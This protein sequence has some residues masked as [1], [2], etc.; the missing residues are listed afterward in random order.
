M[1][2]EAKER[3]VLDKK[4][5]EEPVLVEGS[6]PTPSQQEVSLDLISAVSSAQR[7]LPPVGAPSPMT[8]LP[9]GISPE[10]TTKDRLMEEEIAVHEEAPVIRIPYYILRQR[11]PRILLLE[12]PKQIST[13]AERVSYDQSI[14]A[15]LLIIF[16]A[17]DLSAILPFEV[18]HPCPLRDI[19]FASRT[20]TADTSDVAVGALPD[21][22]SRP[23]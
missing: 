11:M 8:T 13:D 7:G 15:A 21:S 18:R 6:V 10:P 16:A 23:H 5:E 1:K 17:S 2:F 19:R 22:H 4:D 3:E 12:K 14:C 20:C 9:A